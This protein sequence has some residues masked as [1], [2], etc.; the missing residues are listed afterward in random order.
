MKNL[1]VA[2]E[3]SDRA[4][5]SPQADEA[6]GGVLARSRK[7][8]VGDDEAAQHSGTPRIHKPVTTG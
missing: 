3:R 2:A 6:A 8:L 4:D 7:P 5:E 1:D